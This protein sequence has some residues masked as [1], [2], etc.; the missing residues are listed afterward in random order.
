MLFRQP[1]V[2]EGVLPEKLDGGVRPTS[3]KPLPYLWPKS[4]IF[5]TLFMTWPKI[6]H[7]IYDRYGWHSC[8][9]ISYEGL[10]LTVSVLIKK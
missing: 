10:L 6:P 5:A 8:P 7:A 3:Q 2:G 4:A 9:N 1:G